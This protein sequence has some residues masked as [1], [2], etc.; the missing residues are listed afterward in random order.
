MSIH[1][2]SL[3][4]QFA[5]LRA[6]TA[7][8]TDRGWLPAALHALIMAALARIFG[9]LEQLVLLWQT[10]TLPL[11]APRTAAPT[12]PRILDA[13]EGGTRL[14][15]QPSHARTRSARHR[16]AQPASADALQTAATPHFTAGRRTQP[17]AHPPSIIQPSR[18]RPHPARAPPQY[19]APCSYPPPRSGS[20]TC[21]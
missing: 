1:T 2:P 9:R 10:G 6:V 20:R 12:T 5:G 17:S 14:A 7:Q 15:P 4:D 8:S 21:A 18:K 19:P 3:A 16:R 11:P 13:A